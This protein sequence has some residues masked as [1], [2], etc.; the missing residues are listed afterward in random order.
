VRWSSRYAR[1]EIVKSSYSTSVSQSRNSWENA[2]G[3]SQAIEWKAVDE[4]QRQALALVAPMWVSGI[5]FRHA[6]SLV[7]ASD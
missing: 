5:S 6:V 3:C 7:K 1:L 4:D 2:A